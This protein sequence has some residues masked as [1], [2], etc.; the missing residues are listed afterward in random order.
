MIVGTKLDFQPGTEL[1]I[2]VSSVGLYI[3]F[4]P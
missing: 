3:L 4:V 2:N 1:D